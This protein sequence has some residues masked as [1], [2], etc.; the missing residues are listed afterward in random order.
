MTRLSEQRPWLIKIHCSNHRIELAVKDAIK[1]SDFGVV[2][3][4]YINTYNLWEN[5]GKIKTEVKLATET[6]NIQHY[7]Q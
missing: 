6:L 1:E 2:D 4:F 5:S 7:T 3:Q